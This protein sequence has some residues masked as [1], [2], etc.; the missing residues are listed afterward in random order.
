VRGGWRIA[1]RSLGRNRRR[2]LVTGLAIAVGYAGL[3]ALGGYGTRVE[4]MLRMGVV[5]AQR[6][7]HLAVYAPGGFERG[8][9]KPAAHALAPGQ[10]AR[11][12]AALRDDPRVEFTG[13]Y[14]VGGGIAGNGC[15]SFPFRATGVDL[16]AERRIFSH[17]EV[18]AV[19]G[20]LARPREGRLLGEV[21][22][23]S[24]PVMLGVR[25]ARAM[26]KAPPPGGAAPPA[27]PPE[28]L[29][30]EAPDALARIRNDPFV[31]LAART[32]DGAFGAA[33]VWVAGLFQA[34]TTEVDKSAVTA[35]LELLQRVYD[36]DRVTYVAAFLRDHRAAPQVAARLEAALAAEGLRVE[37]RRYDDPEAY[38]YYAGSVGFLG[39]LV[40]FIGLLVAGVV[41]LSVL[42]AMTLAVLER[43]REL[44]TLRALG[45][46]RS[47][48]LRML[49]REAT[50]LSGAALC[51]GL[52]L[53]LAACAAVNAAGLEFEPP[54]VGGKIPLRLTPDLAVSV[55]L[56]AALAALTLA[57]T[58]VAVRRRT[59]AEVAL[60]LSEVTA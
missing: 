35:G 32:H 52:A 3:V 30:C 57:A 6:N 60:L 51:A 36:T 50:I 55:A 23:A 40:G 7:G 4:R 13:R 48:L 21:D 34:F 22:P 53:G 19:A 17:P 25:L 31:Q 16:E 42:N 20:A 33:D 39:A 29:D 11:I 14:L 9:S 12:E 24:A 15:R 38:P 18:L 47:E 10:A 28:P 2:N 26:G 56:G 46:T 8:E 37:I 58:W 54:G 45:F 27:A 1:V 41:S 5:Y 49:L 43:T 59:R 44:G